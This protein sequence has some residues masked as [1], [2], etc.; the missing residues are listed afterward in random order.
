[1]ISPFAACTSNDGAPRAVQ[2]SDGGQDATGGTQVDASSDGTRPDAGDA[3]QVA[4]DFVDLGRSVA[5]HEDWETDITILP[6]PPLSAAVTEEARI[7]VRNQAPTARDAVIELLVDGTLVR[8]VPVSLSPGAVHGEI[9]RPVDGSTSPRHVQARLVDAGGHTLLSHRVATTVLAPPQ[10]VRSLGYA[11]ATWF[12]LFNFLPGYLHRDGPKIE[13]AV[14]AS[15]TATLDG[16]V[17][18]GANT[19]IVSYPEF[20]TTLFHPSTVAFTDYHGTL[21]PNLFPPTPF[22]QFTPWTAAHWWQAQGYQAAPTFEL[23]ELLLAEADVRSMNVFLGLGRSGDYEFSNDVYSANHN[24]GPPIDNKARY[25]PNINDRAGQ[26]I[27]VD[28]RK[29][30]EL[31]SLYGHHRSFYGFY[32]SQETTELSGID[33]AYYSP[34]SSFI[35]TRSPERPVM[36]SC[37]GLVAQLNPDLA[38]AIANGGWDI[39]AMQDSVGAGLTE[40]SGYTYVP[41]ARI[42]ELDGVMSTIRA[43]TDTANVSAAHPKHLWSV[44]EVWEMNGACGYSCPYPATW[45]RVS[46]QFAIAAKYVDVVT[47]N[48]TTGYMRFL[49]DPRPFSDGQWIA[50]DGVPII[51][52]YDSRAR[53]LTGG[54]AVVVTGSS[55]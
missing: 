8:T 10:G 40:L 43:A 29:V 41:S 35:H 34:V 12:E 24:T 52:G 28:T 36:V 16:L 1:M 33:V 11:G 42:Q 20:G 32:L 55:K 37:A 18:V 17:A 49:G 6:P 19:L 15:L 23:F 48:E 2:A 7:A 25:Y 9:V 27:D 13:Q 31:L 3:G 38:Q 4:F 22:S 21:D 44:T 5:T 47:F 53:E 54:Y 30:D 45:E 14:R 51:T 50:A 46:Q 26:L 39:L